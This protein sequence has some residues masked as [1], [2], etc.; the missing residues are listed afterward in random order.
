MGQL[1]QANEIDTKL[2]TIQKLLYDAEQRGAD[3]TYPEMKTIREILIPIRVHFNQDVMSGMT[4]PAPEK[5]VSLKV[6]QL[7][8]IRSLGGELSDPC[9]NCGSMA[10]Q[11]TGTCLTCVNC[12][13]TTGCS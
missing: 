4:I 7:E 5:D 3:D 10:F 6:L 2:A 1:M 9:W 12:Q 11:R 13:E 8:Q